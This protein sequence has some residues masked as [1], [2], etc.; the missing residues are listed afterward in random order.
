MKNITK[1]V[2]IVLIIVFSFNFNLKPQSKNIC[3]FR[4]FGGFG[5]DSVDLN[6][7]EVNAVDSCIEFFNMG[8]PIMYYGEYLIHSSFGKEKLI[9]GF[10]WPDTINV[11]VSVI[12]TMGGVNFIGIGISMV[13]TI[14]NCIVTIFSEIP[15]VSGWGQLDLGVLI[16]KN[17]VNK[18]GIDFYSYSKDSSIIK[19][20]ISLNNMEFKKNGETI[21]VEPFQY[22]W[23]TS[24]EPIP[25][26]VPTGFV[27]EQNYPNP[28]N[29]TTTIRYELGE[30]SMVKLTVYSLLSEEI[31]VLVDEELR[32][33]IYEVP[34]D[35][36]NLAS[37]T[38]IYV[39]QTNNFVLQNKMIVLK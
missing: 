22:T 4:Y 28:F 13:D 7:K 14:A 6:V 15:I 23:P 16:K 24:V 8:Q 35:A 39:L 31:E 9:D 18:I 2:L 25:N 34:F 30:L 32:A 21:L 33:G 5:V 19:T 37:G 29:P 3:G 36:T 17:E 27:L 20:V 11:E 26:L 38:Y 12:D 10:P 1:S